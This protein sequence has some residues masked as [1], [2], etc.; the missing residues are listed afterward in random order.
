[1]P[2]TYAKS[3]GVMDAMKSTIAAVVGLVA[4]VAFAQE[5]APEEQRESDSSYSE[6]G[7]VLAALLDSGSV[8]DRRK[9]TTASP[10]IVFSRGRYPDASFLSSYVPTSIGR[11]RTSVGLYPL[12]TSAVSA[13]FIQEHTGIDTR[14]SL[15][16]ERWL[17]RR[18]GFAQTFAVGH[19]WQDLTLEGTAF[20]SPEDGRPQGAG[21]P[22]KID[23]RSA[24]LSFSPLENWV[25]RL[26]RGTVSGLDHLV[27]GEQVRR[28]AL[29]ATYR[30]AVAEGDWEATIAWGR[31]SRR[32]RESTVGYLVE[33]AYR[34]DGIHSL[35]GR[36]EQVGSDEI[37]REN[38]SLQ[39]QL[40]MMNK[41]TFGYA[42]DLR[43]TSTLRMDVGAYVTR[44]F[45]P[46]SMS[47]SYGSGPTAY[48]MFARV[49]L[50]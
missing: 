9:P 35:F 15:S 45:V 26:T 49:K 29:S 50:Q 3:G 24:R 6:G 39:R 44:Y 4:G 2:G 10:G 34:F 38:E 13:S 22:R 41:L 48:M 42:Q 1:M 33:S 14:A 30:R 27:V 20:S 8:P 12:P 36:F 19:A 37:A 23:S 18:A 21:E 43:L 47:P 5:F 7:D 46:S 28:T 32:F 11:I 40:F 25:V 31:N 17:D 16:A